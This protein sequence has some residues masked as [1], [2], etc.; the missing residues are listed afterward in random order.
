MTRFGTLRSNK[1]A[2]SPYTGFM[3]SDAFC[4]C[5]AKPYCED[6]SAPITEPITGF[7]YSETLYDGQGK[8]LAP[9]V[10]NE[11]IDPTSETFASDLEHAFYCMVRG[12]EFCVRV[13][14]ST[15]EDGNVIVKHQ[16]QSEVVWT[17]A[18]GV[19]ENT[20]NC[21]VAILCLWQVTV[22]A[23]VTPDWNINGVATPLATDFVYTAG[24]D[25]ANT[26]AATTAAA[27][28][29]ALFGGADNVTVEVVPNDTVEG[30]DIFVTAPN[31]VTFD[32][33][34]KPAIK[35]DSATVYVADAEAGK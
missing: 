11:P 18:S 14:V 10:F 30:F 5:S 33:G 9:I 23:G 29:L 3:L 13:K 27:D 32:V 19:V 17:T 34:G 1:K 12:V 35:C 16:G 6:V 15:D 22:G 4:E 25:A 31:D 28:V 26:A 8:E 24:D 21:N 2:N 7:E 20:R